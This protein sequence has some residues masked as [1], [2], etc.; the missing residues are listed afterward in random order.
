[1]KVVL[2]GEIKGKGGEGDVVDVAQGY[3]EN[4]LFPKKLAV[5][6]TKGNLK[7]LEER[8]NNIEKREAVRIA[9]AN[10]LKETLEGKSVVVDAKVGDEGILFGSVTSAMIVDA[11]K[12]QLGVEVDR[13]RVE[14]G[15]AIKVAGSHEVAVSL[16]R[17]IRATVTVLVGV[18][19]EEVEEE[20]EEAAEAAEVA[21]DAEV[22]AE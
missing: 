9:D 5:A 12:D 6:A 22:A 4:Y 11:I 7:Q 21:A 13:K 1:M 8:R 18:T 17:E 20:T 15:K 19:A 2:L 16:Y 14:L 10:S 3:A